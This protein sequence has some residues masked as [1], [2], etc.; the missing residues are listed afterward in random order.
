MSPD[1][2]GRETDA[3]C[4][5]LFTD[6]QPSRTAAIVLEYANNNTKWHEDFGPA[7]QILL[8]HGYPSGHLVEAGVALPVLVDPTVNI[9]TPDNTTTD[10]VT[11]SGLSVRAALAT[12]TV[13][14][15]FSL[16]IH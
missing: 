12:V 1:E 7:F 15:I 9:P 11:D 10:S 8:E 2:T 6:C 3:D 13:G 16:F 4:R 5:A 14:A